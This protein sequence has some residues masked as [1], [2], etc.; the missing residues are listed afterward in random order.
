MELKLKWKENESS[1]KVQC[2]MAPTPTMHSCERKEGLIIYYV[3]K[4]TLTFLKL[5]V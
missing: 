3:T 2:V 5:N 4:A 1:N